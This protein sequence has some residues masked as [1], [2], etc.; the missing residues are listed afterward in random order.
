MDAQLQ[1]IVDNQKEMIA[2]GKALKSALSKVEERV[3]EHEVKDLV[4]A[5][6]ELETSFKEQTETIE[7]KLERMQ[8]ATTDHRGRHR[9]RFFE[10]AD[11]ARGFGLFTVGHAT[12]SKALQEAFK[13]DFDD[14]TVDT[15]AFTSTNADALLPEPLSPAIVDLLEDYGVAEVNMRR[16]PMTSDSRPYTKKTARGGAQPMTEGTAVAE[17]KPT[18]ARKTLTARKWGAYTEVPSEV[19]DDSIMSVAE[20][21]A[22]DMATEHAF[23]LDQATFLGDGTGTYNNITGVLNALGAAAIFAG[24]GNNWG[25]L[26]LGDH[27]KAAGALRTKAYINAK[28]YCSHQYYWNVMVRL[29]L[30]AGGVTAGEI[31]GRRRPLFMGYPVEFTQVMPNATGATQIGA[32]FGNLRQGATFGDRRQ[33]QFKAS[34][35]YKFGEDSI[36]LLSTRRYDVQIDGGGDASNVEVLSAVQTTV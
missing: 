3:G 11:Q 34:E 26:T 31:E 35:H 10:T 9:S 36:A 7:K 14:I 24:S 23:A 33:F 32:M 29:M 19:T 17:T 5:V 8:R 21:I 12:G 13:S 15:K 20:M 25:A 18:L 4:D 22:D 6:E 28:W 27:E 1:E 30:E 16:E 2:E